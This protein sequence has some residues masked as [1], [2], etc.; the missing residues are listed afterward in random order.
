MVF[1]HPG[2]WVCDHGADTTEDQPFEY[3]ASHKN[4]FAEVIPV[5]RGNVLCWHGGQ[6]G[7]YDDQLNS[8]ADYDVDDVLAFLHLVRENAS[9]IEAAIGY[10]DPTPLI[11]TDPDYTGIMGGSRGGS[12]TYLAKLRDTYYLT[13][14]GDVNGGEIKRA[15]VFCGSVTDWFSQDIKTSC[16]FY[17]HTDGYVPEDVRH[18]YNED[19][20]F[21][22]RILERY[23]S[24]DPEQHITFEEAR[25]RMLLS[26]PRWMAKDG[27]TYVLH[28]VQINH[29]VLDDIV[30][31]GQSDAL[32]PV[33]F[34]PEQSN[35]EYHHYPGQ[36]H[37]PQ[38]GA[39]EGAYPWDN[40]NHIID[41]WLDRVIDG[42]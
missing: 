26:S 24:T 16:Q 32:W 6:I 19:Y 38:M 15:I 9:D 1:C 42:I 14:G 34:P 33:L 30:R 35:S 28:H 21:F 8:P 18:Y 23:L 13:N 11:N 17:L 41:L 12:P 40:Y 5:Y 22:K 20:N 36:G 3:Y 27:S 29:G 31:K 39:Q 10:D 7:T 25:H 37:V 2:R 4:Q